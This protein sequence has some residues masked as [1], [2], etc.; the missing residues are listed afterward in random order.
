MPSILRFYYDI[1]PTAFLSK[2]Q[3]GDSAFDRLGGFAN[4]I[5]VSFC[6]RVHNNH[7]PSH[8]HVMRG[9]EEEDEGGG[10]RVAGCSHTCNAAC[11]HTDRSPVPHEHCSWGLHQIR[12]QFKDQDCA[13]HARCT[14]SPPPPPSLSPLFPAAAASI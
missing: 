4:D 7:V 6:G 5:S 9:R 8:S 14:P 1:L 2:L 13:L 11:L 10:G 12:P 3:N